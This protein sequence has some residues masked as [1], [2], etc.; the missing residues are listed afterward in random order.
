[1][2]FVLNVIVTFIINKKLDKC[3]NLG[4]IV[5]KRMRNAQVTNFILL[6]VTLSERK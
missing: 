2:R 3:S 1:M 5:K 6:N 4:N